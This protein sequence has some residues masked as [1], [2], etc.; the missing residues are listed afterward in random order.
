MDKMGSIENKL[1]PKNQA[2]KKG[3]CISI[4]TNNQPLL[5]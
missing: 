3:D 5:F 4:K 1:L 2:K